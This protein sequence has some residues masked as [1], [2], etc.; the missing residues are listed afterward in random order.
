MK[1]KQ[2]LYFSIILFTVIPILLFGWLA[3]ELNANQQEN[4]MAENL[5]IV[6]GAQLQEM[7]TFCQQQ[8]ENMSII[9]EMDTVR[10]FLKD[11][12]SRNPS[13]VAYIED[14]LASRV[15]VRDY[16]YSMTI[17]DRDYNIIACSEPYAEGYIRSQL[18]IGEEHF[19]DR[20]LFISDVIFSKSRPEE[21]KELFAMMAIRDHGEIIG[22][23]MEEINLDF[24]HDL[25][26]RTNLWE[27]STFYLLD[28]KGQ[29]ITAGNEE[30]QVN[31]F[32]TTPE[33]REDYLRQY[34]AID[35]E[36]N[37]AGYI[38]YTV[39]GKQY[40]TYYSKVDYTDWM[41][42]LT[43]NVDR[44]RV[45]KDLGK[46]L[47]WLTAIVCVILIVWINRFST[48]RIFRPISGISDVLKKIQQEQNYSLRIPVA[49]KDE[50]GELIQEINGLIDYIEIEN[51]YEKQQQRELKVRA[52]QDS[53]TKVL[54]KSSAIERLR[55]LLEENSVN[56]DYMAVLFVDVDDFKHFNTQY[57]HTVGD[58]VLLFVAAA[59]QRMTEGIVGRFGGD[60]FVVII[61][62]EDV[63]FNLEERLQQLSR[64]LQT[65]F[66]ERGKPNHRIPI[67]CCIG[68]ALIG[69]G[70][71]TVEQVID[72]ADE[73]MY[74][75]KNRGKKGYAVRML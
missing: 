68:V 51:L 3:M 35:L 73:A 44:Y 11:S 60:E 67:S 4:L 42:Q 38:S 25:R 13:T 50:M 1:I 27:D 53:L 36:K 15:K 52:E 74:E 40:G 65:Q 43:I 16:L 45:Q 22:Y 72:T 24:Y 5:E 28:G 61:Q 31:Q 57:G 62:N 39:A 18:A 63:L 56:D 30:N 49:K 54:N 29:I 48:D 33:E 47:L 2:I 19:V 55:E 8:W 12:S 69:R 71:F 37:P 17:I 23:I 21:R 41:L 9:A 46:A 59:L 66:I 58:Q 6:T 70:S 10:R 64:V 7:N 14:S 34:Q 26:Q 20:D 32:V 75:V